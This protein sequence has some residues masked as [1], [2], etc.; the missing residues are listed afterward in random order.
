MKGKLP[1]LTTDDQGAAD[2]NLSRRSRRPTQGERD[3]HHDGVEISLERLMELR[4]LFDMIDYNGRGVVDLRQLR[5]FFS[6]A[7][8]DLNDLDRVLV[9]LKGRNTLAEDASKVTFTRDDFIDMIL[10]EGLVPCAYPTPRSMKASSEQLWRCRHARV[11]SALQIPASLQ[12][13]HHPQDPVEVH[14]DALDPMLDANGSP[15]TALDLPQIPPLPSPAAPPSSGGDGTSP[16]G[17]ET[18]M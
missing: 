11:L 3:L 9:R 4:R 5:G 7:L 1:G 15:R 17:G 12:G 6:D 16:S 8:D 10:P 2:A 18:M 14:A 13:Y